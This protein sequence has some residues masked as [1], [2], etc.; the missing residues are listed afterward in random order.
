VLPAI[1]RDL[2]AQ[3]P[4][5]ACELVLSNATTDLLRREADIAVRMA[6]PTQKALVAR[7]VGDVVLGL[8]AHP[9]YLAARGTPTSIGDLA[10]H[11]I[12]GYDRDRVAAAIVRPSG[13]PLDR[14][15]F[16]YRIDNQIAQLAAIRAGCGIGLCQVRLAERPPR[17]VRLLADEVALP[18]ET[19]V[20][21]HED[22][23]GDRRM[24][25]TFDHLHAAMSAYATG[26]DAEMSW[27]SDPGEG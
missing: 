5:L 14:D 20:V 7:R 15:R 9:D 13:L 23:R 25:A 11:E 24:R 3:H 21:M 10:R 4:E 17:L 6:R 2:R 19:W 8:H 16:A 1:L 18:L 12:V 27:N 22:L 26:R